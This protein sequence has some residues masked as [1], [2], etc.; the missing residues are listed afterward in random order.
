MSAEQRYPIR[1]LVIFVLIAVGAF[2]FIQLL[3]MAFMFPTMGWMMTDGTGE[4]SPSWS[5][6]MTVIYLLGLVVFGYIIY[7]VYRQY[8]R[9]D[10]AIEELRRAYARGELTQ[11]E[12]E[13]RRT[14]LDRSN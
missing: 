5:I 2:V 11:E 4:M 10:A 1:G 13:Q 9:R 12:F 6:G 8:A 3:M 7:R 14:D